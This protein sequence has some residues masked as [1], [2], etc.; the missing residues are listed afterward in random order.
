MQKLFLF[1]LLFLFIN[2]LTATWVNNSTECNTPEARQFDF[3]VGEWDIDQKILQKDG[4]WLETKAHTSV[5]PILNGCALEEHWSGEVKF[6][7]LGMEEI[8]PMNGFSIRY[9][10]P[11]K[12]KWY[13]HWI[14]NFNLAFGD[15][16]SGNF[17]DGKGEFL[18]ETDTTN[19][20]RISKITFSDITDN[21][22][23][24]DLAISNDNG[25]SWT[26]IW[27][28]EMKRASE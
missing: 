9:Y 3:W 28:M 14:D 23:Y 6:F 21:S 1:I 16:A 7:W 25:N 5:S 27:I 26:V 18:S 13:I 20:K 2:P 24:W 8:K 15:G 19:G 12:K 11:E 4:S 22:V 10:N 17:K